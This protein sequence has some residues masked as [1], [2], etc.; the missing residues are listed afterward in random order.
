MRKRERRKPY[1]RAQRLGFGMTEPWGRSTA[2]LKRREALAY[3]TT[4]FIATIVAESQNRLDKIKR[5]LERH[6]KHS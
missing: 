4:N 1:V 2:E 3:E 5:D 6:A